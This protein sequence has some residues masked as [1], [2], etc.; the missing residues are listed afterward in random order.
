MN[1]ETNIFWDSLTFRLFLFSFWGIGWDILVTLTQHI[2]AGKTDINLI[3]PAST[4]M[5]LAYGGIALVIWPTTNVM[6][7]F[8]ISYVF[9]IIILL[10][11]FYVIEYL[12]GSTM[13]FFG[14]KPWDYNWNIP[15][16]WTY[17]G[18]IT[19]HPVILLEWIVFIVIV[20]CLDA[21]FIKSWPSLKAAF[22]SHFQ[23]I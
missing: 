12:F 4:W 18:I 13:Y 8:K 17:N 14:I 10:V 6:K 1:K 3:N 5:Y 19:W 20:D 23:G 2:I 22:K 7:K 21:V 15:A 11:I 16:S 9:R